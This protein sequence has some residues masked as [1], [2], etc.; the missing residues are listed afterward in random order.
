LPNR[1]AFAALA[2][3][4]GAIGEFM[5]IPLAIIAGMAAIVAVVALARRPRAQRD[6][7]G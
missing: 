3:F 1:D 2:F 6:V 4:R 7:V 5:N